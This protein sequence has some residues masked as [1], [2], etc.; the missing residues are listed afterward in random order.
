ML[1]LGNSAKVYPAEAH[2]TETE[3]L[4]H[5]IIRAWSYIIL[6]CMM[7]VPEVLTMGYSLYRMIM[8]KESPLQTSTLLWVGWVF[9]RNVI[10]VFTPPK[11][12]YKHGTQEQ[13]SHEKIKNHYN[14]S[15]CDVFTLPSH[16]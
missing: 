11:A 16:L 13:L 1:I 7:L 6:L 8:K 3:R 9:V 5:D 12:K 10:C 2:D 14:L 15:L 4:E